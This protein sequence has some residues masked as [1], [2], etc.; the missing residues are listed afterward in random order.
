[1]HAVLAIIIEAKKFAE[2][3]ARSLIPVKTNQEI[4]KGSPVTRPSKLA[5][6]AS[7]VL[8]DDAGKTLKQPGTSFSFFDQKQTLKQFRFQKKQFEANSS[9]RKSFH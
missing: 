2:K 9:E 3:S 1:M 8:S 6:G 7:A 4:K 5:S